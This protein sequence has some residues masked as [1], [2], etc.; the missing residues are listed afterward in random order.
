MYILQIP[1]TLS[2]NTA[3]LYT[4]LAKRLKEFLI[5][6]FDLICQW[7][8]RNIERRQLMKLDD[9][10]LTDIGLDRAT[11]ISEGRKPFWRA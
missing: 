8:E 4:P 2:H 11:A 5:G 10:M 7:H 1:A 6:F 3:E 9:R